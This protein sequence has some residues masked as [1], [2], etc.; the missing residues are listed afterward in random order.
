GEFSDPEID[1]LL[2]QGRTT[3]GVENRLPIYDEIQTKLLEEHNPQIYCNWGQPVI[4]HRSW[5]KGYGATP[6]TVSA[7][8]ALYKAWLEGKPGV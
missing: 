2:E 7:N 4:A 6:N 3:I 5:L 1:A 8:Y